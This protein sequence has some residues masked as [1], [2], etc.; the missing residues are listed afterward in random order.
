[1]YAEHAD[2][3][4]QIHS[5]QDCR[6][7]AEKIYAVVDEF[8]P[9]ASTLLDVGCGSGRQIEHLRSRF[10]VAGLDID[11][12]MLAIARKRLGLE[13][14]LFEAD[15]ADFALDRRFDVVTCLFGS[16][17]FL[18]TLE[19]LRDAIA[20]MARHL[21]SGGVLLIEPWLSP[22]QYW[23]NNIKLN[24]SEVPNRKIAWMYVGREEGNI[25][26][27]DVHYLVGEPDGVTHFTQIQRHRLHS[28]EDFRAAFAAAGLT[29][30]Q[31]EPKG[32]FGYGLYVALRDASHT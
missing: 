22:A 17:S 14:E 5:F 6:E 16:I 26:T 18:L 10:R 20:A 19:N 12:A 32:L 1:M 11:P 29:M 23:R 28:D 2:L 27:E 4:D 13:V 8:N 3:Y 25:V 9:S 7:A 15:M 30:V 24:I 21:A 31:Y